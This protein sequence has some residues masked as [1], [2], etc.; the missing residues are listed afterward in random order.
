LPLL[1]RKISIRSGGDDVVVAIERPESVGDPV[2]RGEKSHL[3][4]YVLTH[5]IILFE[6][7]DPSCEFGFTIERI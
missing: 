4:E 6:S 2:L 1:S 3:Y 7:R 5:P